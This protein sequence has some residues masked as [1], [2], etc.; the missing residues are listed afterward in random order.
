MPRKYRVALIGCG[1]IARLHARSIT[2]LPEAEL[3]ALADIRPETIEQ[4]GD[5]Y[6]IPTDRR[7]TD[8][9]EL[10]DEVRPDIAIVATR[11]DTHA[12]I[13][14]V[15]LDR[16][17][18]VLCEKPIAVDLRE[19]DAMIEASVRCDAKLA[20]N[21]QR[22][23]D[24]VFLHA[25]RLV[26][27]GAVG[28]LRVIRSECK[29]YTAAVGMMNIG[30]HLFDAM[31]LIGGSPLWVTADITAHEGRRISTA[32]ITTGDRGTGLA[33]G[34]VATVLIGYD[35]G[36]TGISEYWEGVG[37]YGFEVVGTRAILAIRGIDPVLYRTTGGG[38]KVNEP[39][40][41]EAVDVPLSDAD[42]KV[43]EANRWG[44]QFMMRDLIR[45][46]ENDEQPSCSGSAGRS[47]MEIN[48]AAFLSARSGSRVQIPL[49][50]RDHPLK[51]WLSESTQS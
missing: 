5:T 50:D 4:F 45:A 9:T 42:R 14:I 6:G 12:E 1:G 24:P 25:K 29:T 13:T 22:H 32:D 51:S 43:F 38:G 10:L 33:V 11:A 35:G 26:S 19:A 23:T 8:Y 17:I 37:T 18:N 46:I 47:A 48:H 41:W 2:D 36:V 31:N 30:S 49:Q 44:T 20:I 7:H 16:G 27:E 21:T 34:D 15:A 39:I 3:V 40:V 28:E